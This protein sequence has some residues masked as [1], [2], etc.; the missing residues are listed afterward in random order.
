MRATATDL[1]L[2]GRDYLH[3]DGFGNLKVEEEEEEEARIVLREMRV[4]RS[5]GFS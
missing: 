2:L 5:V 1:L 3:A 4:G